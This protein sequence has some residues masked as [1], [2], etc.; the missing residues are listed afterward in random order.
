MV[1][2]QRVT[3][4]GNESEPIVLSIAERIAALNNR[5][6]SDRAAPPP[7]PS[8]STAST[9]PITKSDVVA[10]RV[11][12]LSQNS[13]TSTIDV[14]EK[15][16]VGKLKPQDGAPMIP[17]GSGPP[18]S[19]LK[20]QKEREERMEKLQQEAKS[21][22]TELGNAAAGTNPKVGKL[23]LPAGAVPIMAFGAGP[24]PPLL[25]KK[26]RE[27]EELMEKLREEARLTEEDESGAA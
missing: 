15:P 10:S 18:P 13:K 23:N 2:R 20:K 1:P 8:S 21:M 7:P 12:A 17:F 6:D 5:Y 9:K 3:M 11:A 24:P 25:L 27:R 16:K 4:S 14:I 26:Q 19:L 22:D